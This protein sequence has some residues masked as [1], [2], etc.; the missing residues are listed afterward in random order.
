[1]S[2]PCTGVCQGWIKHAT[3]I[4]NCYPTSSEETRPK[5]SELSYLVFYAKSKPAKL[6][7][8]GVYL[9]KRVV[10]DI[11]KKRKQ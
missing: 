2:M 10:T 6:T 1:M 7:K 3:L 9:E 8:C 4:N 11:R 5:S